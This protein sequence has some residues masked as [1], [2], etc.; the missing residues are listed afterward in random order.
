MSVATFPGSLHR[1][2]YR[3][4][5]C[6]FTRATSSLASLS[7]PPDLMRVER[8]ERFIAV[9]SLCLADEFF[10]VLYCLLV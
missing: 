1:R 5:E 7:G 10:S 8:L 3:H 6:H 4:V 2:V 9:G